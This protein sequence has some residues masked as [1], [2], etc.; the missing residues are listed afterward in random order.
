METR[1]KNV[2]II[3]PGDHTI[4]AVINP[5]PGHSRSR[6][7]KRTFSHLTTITNEEFHPILSPPALSMIDIRSH[8]HRLVF[9]VYG[10]NNYKSYDE[11]RLK[12]GAE[13]PGEQ[14]RKVM[15]IKRPKRSTIILFLADVMIIGL[16][17][18]TLE[19]LITLLLRNEEL[20]RPRVTFSGLEDANALHQTNGSRHIPR[21]LHQT[22]ATE[23]IPDK[24]VEPQRSCKEAYRDFEYKV[25]FFSNSEVNVFLTSITETA[26]D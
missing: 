12:W 22:T 18:H 11:E 7:G 23:I 24:W 6:V 5:Q 1:T 10:T 16:L 25:S 19:P 13:P 9:Q 26:V 17:L 14:R 4:M 21:I 20:F 2:V 3:F 8:F 15:L